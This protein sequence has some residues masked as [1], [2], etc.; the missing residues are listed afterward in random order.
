M[1]VFFGFRLLTSVLPDIIHEIF[2]L[3]IGKKVVF[4]MRRNGY[5]TLWVLTNKETKRGRPESCATLCLSLRR[6]ER[7]A[8]GGTRTLNPLRGLV[9]ETSAYTIPPRRL[10]DS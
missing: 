5:G 8:G 4:L 6:K 10:I 1:V 9:F 3:I 2:P 7:S